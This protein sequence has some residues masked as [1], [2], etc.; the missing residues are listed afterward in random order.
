[1]TELRF[2]VVSKSNVTA[3][4]WRD[5]MRNVSDLCR[6]TPFCS[7]S[8]SIDDHLPKAIA[9]A[10]HLILAERLGARVG[11]ALF[12]VRPLDDEVYVSTL[13]G[14]RAGAAII[15]ALIRYLHATPGLDRRW[16]VLDSTLGASL[17]YVKMGFY[18]YRV[19]DR[20]HRLYKRDQTFIGDVL[21]RYFAQEPDDFR[22]DQL[23]AQL[24]AV[25][26]WNRVYETL[27]MTLPL[28][29]VV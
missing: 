21:K 22:L 18:F 10:S 16:L 20:R 9:L 7:E 19:G 1:M 28:R 2:E 27:A 26:S 12:E 25:L 14:I 8:L 5:H 23:K 17:F 24:G 6:T 13:F 15:E 3:R 4:T 11:F 29:V